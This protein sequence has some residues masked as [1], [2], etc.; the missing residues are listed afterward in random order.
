M[1]NLSQRCVKV[2]KTGSQFWQ[3]FV[4]VVLKFI[5]VDSTFWDAPQSKTFDYELI[6]LQIWLFPNASEYMCIFGFKYIRIWIAHG[7]KIWMANPSF[8]PMATAWVS[9]ALLTWVL[10]RKIERKYIKGLSRCFFSCFT[11]VSPQGQANVT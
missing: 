1:S 4:K 8:N 11:T 9:A 6:P 3:S 10:I 2:V 7:K 5:K